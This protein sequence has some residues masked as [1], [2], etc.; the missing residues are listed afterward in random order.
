MMPYRPPQRQQ[1][2]ARQRTPPLRQPS[3]THQRNSSYSQATNNSDPY[4]SP[5]NSRNQTRLVQRWYQAIQLQFS[6]VL[7]DGSYLLISACKDGNPMLR[8]GATGDWIGTFKGHK[9]AVWCARLNMDA[10]RAV[11][12]SADFSAKVWDT[13]SGEVLHTFQHKHIVRAVDISP[14]GRYVV[15]GGHEKVVRM[16]DLSSPDAAPRLAMGH[17]ATIKGIVWDQWHGVLITHAEERSVRIWDLRTLKQTN[18]LETQE[19]VTSV[20]LSSDGAVIS[21]TAG[22]AVYFWDADTYELVKTINMT[23]EA[24]CVTLHP[25][26]ARFVVGSSSDL[27]VRVYDLASGQELELYKGHHGPVHT[28]SYSPDGEVY[29]TGSE[30]GTIRLW[31]TIP[32]TE[33]GLWQAQYTD[34]EAAH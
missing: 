1:S 22:K 20:E 31:Q 33:Y 12:A 18:L 14:D 7:E 11:T 17:E 30:D 29:A 32:G 8:I 16:Y 10:S 27:W 2:P 9:G 21:A 34:E 4:G 28:V 13:F 25:T 5:S 6:P 23:F 24:S 15:S 26:R 3:P 19:R